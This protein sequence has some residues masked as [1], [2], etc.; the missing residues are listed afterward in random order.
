M[1]NRFL[2]LFSTDDC[3]SPLQKDV[4]V[5]VDGTLV[6]CTITEC[7][8]LLASGNRN[9]LLQQAQAFILL[10][11]VANTESL[12]GIDD[13]MQLISM[14]HEGDVRCAHVVGVEMSTTERVCSVQDGFDMAGKHH[15]PFAEITYDSIDQWVLV[16]TNVL[17]L[18]LWQRAGTL[19]ADSHNQLMEHILTKSL[20]VAND[21]ASY[22]IPLDTSSTR[23]KGVS[24]NEY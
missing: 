8:A 3:R 5:D 2:T 22:S 14:F 4:L 12:R 7:S 19:L 6:R 16:R 10:Y 13:I 21:R 20:A 17:R 1:S 9:R 18:L 24:E 23:I 15:L 11:D